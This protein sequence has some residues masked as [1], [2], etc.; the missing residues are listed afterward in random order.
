MIPCTCG[1][2]LKVSPS[3]KLN[4]IKGRE[5]IALRARVLGENETL[6][7]ISGQR[8]GTQNRGSKR[9][10]HSGQSGSRKRLK[11]D[12][13]PTI[14]EVDTNPTDFESTFLEDVPSVATQSTTSSSHKRFRATPGPTTF[15]ADASPTDYESTFPED[16]PSV[17]TRSTTN[18]GCR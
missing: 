11:T 2:G 12:P 3:T 17:A 18:H 9:T 13:G 14:F 7:T 4:H 1:C 10:F 8:Q 6:R 15:E 5:T 16:I